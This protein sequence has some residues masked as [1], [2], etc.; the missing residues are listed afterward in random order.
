MDQS[1]TIT[2]TKHYPTQNCTLVIRGKTYH[3]EGMSL[4]ELLELL[5]DD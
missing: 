2:I 5:F 1:K 4:Y 3:T